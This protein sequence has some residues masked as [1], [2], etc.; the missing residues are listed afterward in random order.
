MKRDNSLYT[1][2]SYLDNYVLMI[3]LVYCVV[4]KLPSRTTWLNNTDES[5]FD[6]EMSSHS[7][8]SPIQRSGSNPPLAIRL[9][10]YLTTPAASPH[11]PSIAAT[12][13][14][15]SYAYSL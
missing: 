2:A 6:T 8:P 9:E 3:C 13:T 15:E 5:K 4:T 10:T 12:E 1:K 7:M 11:S 14:P